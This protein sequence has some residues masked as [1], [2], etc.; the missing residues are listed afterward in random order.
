VAVAKARLARQTTGPKNAQ[1]VTSKERALGYYE[2][3]D[4]QDGRLEAPGATPGVSSGHLSVGN[5]QILVAVM[6]GGAS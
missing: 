2:L 1:G 4:L 5:I 6:E 3:A